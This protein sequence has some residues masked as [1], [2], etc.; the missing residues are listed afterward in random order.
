MLFQ[1]RLFSVAIVFDLFNHNVV[2]RMLCFNHR[3]K[4][5]TLNNYLNLFQKIP[6]F[7]ATAP[8]R[9]N[10]FLTGVFL[11]I[12]VLISDQCCAFILVYRL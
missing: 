11:F 3:G 4:V 1:Y 6:P 7:D 8:C 10:L 9:I 2:F 5:F 12:P